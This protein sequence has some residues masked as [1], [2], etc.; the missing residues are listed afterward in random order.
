MARQKSNMPPVLFNILADA[1]LGLT[2]GLGDALGPAR[3]ETRSSRAW[4]RSIIADGSGGV[5]LLHRLEEWNWPVAVPDLCLSTGWT[6]LH[7]ALR[8]PLQFGRSTMDLLDLA[9]MVIAVGYVLDC[10][11][12]LEAVVIGGAVG[13]SARRHP[14]RRREDRP[15][16]VRMRTAAIPSSSCPKDACRRLARM[17]GPRSSARKR[18]ALISQTSRRNPPDRP[19]PRLASSRHRPAVQ[20]AVHEEHR[21]PYCLEPV[22]RNDARGVV[23]CQVCHTLHHKDC[24]DITGNCQVPHLNT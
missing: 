11:A 15:A 10:L 24:W 9:H 8:L 14:H 12:G 2:G 6:G 5:G 1:S 19:K 13:G 21:C 23:E 7:I 3:A 20:L 17:S 16:L 18:R 22:K 4:R